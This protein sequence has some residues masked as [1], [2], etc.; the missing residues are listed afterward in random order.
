MGLG[1]RAVV[2]FR[3][4]G[5]GFSAS[6]LWGLGVSKSMHQEGLTP[7]GLGC[8]RGLDDLK[9][10]GFVLLLFSYDKGRPSVLGI[11]SPC[12]GV[13]CQIYRPLDS[14]GTAGESRSFKGSLPKP[15]KVAKNNGP[16]TLKGYYSTYFWGPGNS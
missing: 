10:I 9:N 7:Q 14:P 1:I 4:N 2:N 16:R 5:L 6:G 8:V 11:R 15:P 3:V 13:I 12:L